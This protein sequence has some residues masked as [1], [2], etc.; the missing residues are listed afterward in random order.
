MNPKALN[1]ISAL[2][3]QGAD[4]ETIVNHLYRT[5]TVGLLKLWGHVLNSLQSDKQLSLA[6]SLIPASVFQTTG[7]S[8]AELGDLMG[9]I[10]NHSSEAK[11]VALI[12]E[13]L[14]NPGD[15]DIEISTKPPLHAKDLMKDF[16][17]VGGERIA[18]AVLKNS[19]LKDAEDRL[20][21]MIK[22]RL[23]LLK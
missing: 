9:E 8:R 15:I 3:H 17:P 14:S 19:S 12:I 21:P 23:P 6:W 16:Q 22:K 13:G 7:T 10:L 4:H 20:I 2:I 5:K 18:T 11:T 1:L